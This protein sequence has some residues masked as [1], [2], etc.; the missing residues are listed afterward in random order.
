MKP[1]GSG[2]TQQPP[3]ESYIGVDGGSGRLFRFMRIGLMSV[4]EDQPPGGGCEFVPA[5]Q[6]KGELGEALYDT[7]YPGTKPGGKDSP[8]SR[9]PVLVFDR[10]SHVPLSGVFLFVI[11][12]P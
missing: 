5:L 1:V 11:A 3:E 8:C 10:P 12:R 7:M 2:L 9:V 6:M 4:D